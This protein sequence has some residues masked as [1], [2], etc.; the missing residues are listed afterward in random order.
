MLRFDRIHFVD[1]SDCLRKLLL[2]LGKFCKQLILVCDMGSI[3][4]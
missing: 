4:L 3:F 2:E 1:Q